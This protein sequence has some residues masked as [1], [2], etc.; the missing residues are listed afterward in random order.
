[1]DSRSWIAPRVAGYTLWPKFSGHFCWWLLLPVCTSIRDPCTYM[2]ITWL[3]CTSY[4]PLNTSSPLLGTVGVI[5]VSHKMSFS[6]LVKESVEDMVR[7]CPFLGTSLLSANIEDTG[8]GQ[9]PSRSCLLLCCVFILFG[10]RKGVQNFHHQ[11]QQAKSWQQVS[12]E[13]QTPSFPRQSGILSCSF[14]TPFAI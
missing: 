9:S 13:E 3:W 5:R 10:L 8:Q 2:I 14:K 7:R 4:R 6:S 11:G 1:M 12:T